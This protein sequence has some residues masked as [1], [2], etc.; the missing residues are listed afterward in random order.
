MLYFLISLY[1]ILYVEIFLVLQNFFTCTFLYI[2]IPDFKPK[3][4]I[5]YLVFW[6]LALAGLLA[7]RSQS[8]VFGGPQVFSLNIFLI[9]LVIRIL[10]YNNMVKTFINTIRIN[11]LNEKLEALSTTDELTKL[12]NQR[13]LTLW[14]IWKVIRRL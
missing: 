14:G 10:H 13:S 3:I 2:F 8:F 12:N 6:Y 1:S 11:T 7:Y 9:A 4:F 5:S